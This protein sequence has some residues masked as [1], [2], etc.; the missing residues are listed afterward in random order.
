MSAHSPWRRPAPRYADAAVIRAYLER[1]DFTGAASA[2]ESVL[3]TSPDDRDA[4][5]MLAVAQRYLQNIP[6][7]LATLER[8]ERVH[9]AF[10]RLY[11]ERGHCYLARRDAQRAIDAFQR[12]VIRNPA[13][14]ASWL[15]LQML[16]RTNDQQA[17]TAAASQVEVRSKLAPEVLA[18]TGLFSVG[19]LQGAERLIRCYLLRPGNAQDVEALRLLARIAL[20]QET[21]EDADVLREANPLLLELP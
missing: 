9:P 15:K 10:S 17:S 12:A 16:Y 11:Q 3:A 14:P 19:D 5:Y 1:R 8:L 4:L 13:L 2:C 20:E 21:V 6:D 18:A 7:A